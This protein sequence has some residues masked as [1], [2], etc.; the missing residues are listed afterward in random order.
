MDAWKQNFKPIFLLVLINLVNLAVYSASRDSLNFK[1]SFYITTRPVSDAVLAPNVQVG[2]RTS[3]FNNTSRNQYLQVGFN[4]LNYALYSPRR[5]LYSYYS[6][7][8]KQYSAELDYRFLL[9]KNKFWAPHFQFSYYKMDYTQYFNQFNVAG[10]M[11]EIGFQ[12]GRIYHKPG[13]S[14]MNV[15]Y[16]GF[17]VSQHQWASIDKISRF[18]F[19]NMMVYLNWQFGFKS[20]N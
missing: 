5:P 3:D 6:E 20:M 1:A 2:F 14:W 18:Q 16:W 12:N 11:Y 4:Y 17:G 7:D 8:L 15:L 13:K 10:M 19:T 9:R